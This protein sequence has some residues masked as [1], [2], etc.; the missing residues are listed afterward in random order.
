MSKV[1]NIDIYSKISKFLAITG[2]IINLYIFLSLYFKEGFT[3]YIIS[4][5]TSISILIYFLLDYIKRKKKTE[6]D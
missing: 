3:F 6:S 4:L 2:A 1:E 5:I